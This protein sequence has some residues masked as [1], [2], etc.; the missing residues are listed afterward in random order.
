MKHALIFAVSCSFIFTFPGCGNQ[1]TDHQRNQIEEVQLL[2]KSW[3]KPIP[4]QTPPEGLTSLSAEE[5][6]EC[7]VE[8]YREWKAS[9]H[10]QA[11]HDPQFQAEWAK[12]DSLWVCVNCHTPLE[13]Q[14]EFLILGK[15]GG[16]Y[17]QPVKQANPRFDR[18][19]REEAI[20]CAVCHVRD[21][22]VIG[23]Y[24]NHEAAPHAVQK[25]SGRLSQQMCLSCHN[26][27]DALS[28]TLIC[29]FQTGEEW[30]AS[31]YAELGEDCISCH[32]PRVDR[33]I[34]DDGAIRPTRKH[35]W[36]GSGIPKF[37][38]QKPLM[39]GYIPGLDVQIVS[40]RNT[41]QTGKT[42]FFT[43][44]L[45]NQRAGHFL[46]TGDPEYF[47]TLGLSLIDKEGKA[48]KDTTYRIGQEWQWWPEAK[49]LS[50]NRLHPR[51]KRAYSFFFTIPQNDADHKFQVTVTNHRMTDE[52]AEAMGLLGRYPLSAVVFKEENP[53]LKLP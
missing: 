52:N 48:L 2:T 19:L 36:V 15:K 16:D 38:D 24:G 37:T 13:N 29:T 41:Y 50:D 6:G 42:A 20:T 8:I 33:P 26:V 7:H 1:E 9:F 45:T 4:Y 34:I 17:F 12:D 18:S 22:V 30:R 35:T 31:P 23:P 47:I 39:D 11:W 40:S 51:E 28:P 10:A 21:K 32:M 25:D 27:E 14:Q 53:P 3:E 5:C 44:I 46:P 49:R 43:V